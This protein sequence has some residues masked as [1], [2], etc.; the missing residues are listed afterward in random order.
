VLHGSTDIGRPHAFL[1]IDNE[2]AFRRATEHLLDI[3]HRRI[4]L[5]TGPAGL[6]FAEHREKG[7]RD[8]MASRGVPV[9]PHWVTNGHFF[10][11]TGFAQAQEMLEQSPR[12]TAILASSMTTVLGVMRAIRTA[13][14]EVGRDVSVLAHDDVFPFLNADNMVPSLST[15]RSAIRAAGVRVADFMLQMLGGRPAED[16]HEIWPVELV[17][18]QSTMPPPPA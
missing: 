14:L 15:T 6:S 12:P 3:G 4:A 11:E 2:G 8:A 7:F 17:L 13:G 5:I 9:P 18:R 10:D 1:D 16:L